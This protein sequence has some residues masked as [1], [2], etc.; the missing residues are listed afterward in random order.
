MAGVGPARTTSHTLQ[1]PPEQAPT[2]TVKLVSRRIGIQ[3]PQHQVAE[4]EEQKSN[5]PPGLGGVGVV[6]EDKPLQYPPH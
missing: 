3:E 2:H 6:F 4:P 5:I 1:P